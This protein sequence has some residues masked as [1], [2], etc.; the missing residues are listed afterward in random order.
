M[1]NIQV[2]TFIDITEYSQLYRAQYGVIGLFI[3]NHH[4]MSSR[5]YIQR[6]AE[7]RSCLV[8]P[9]NHSEILRSAHAPHSNVFYVRQNEQRLF[10]YTV[11]TDCFYNKDGECLLRGTD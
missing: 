3:G 11:L 2:S 9:L 8:L 4:V 10:P 5:E 6:Y 1:Y 7:Y